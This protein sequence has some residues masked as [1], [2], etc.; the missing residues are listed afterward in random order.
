MEQAHH[1]HME[2]LKVK[3]IH[4]LYPMEQD[5]AGENRTACPKER[6]TVKVMEGVLVIQLD[7]RADIPRVP[8]AAWDF[9]Q[10]LGITSPTSGWIS[11]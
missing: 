1:N 6:A 2:N 5:K 3:A 9:L 11:R 10:V 8:A 7:Q 4:S